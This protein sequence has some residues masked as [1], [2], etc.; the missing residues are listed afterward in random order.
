MDINH[1]LDAALVVI[2]AVI[3]GASIILKGIGKITG[4]W[5]DSEAFA[6]VTAAQKVVHRLQ[7]LLGHLGLDT[8]QS[9]RLRAKDK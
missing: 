5:P 8:S 9:N 4:I 3:A 1:I 6:M 7:Q 2:P